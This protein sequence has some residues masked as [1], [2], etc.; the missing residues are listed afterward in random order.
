M[1]GFVLTKAG[2]V[3][4]HGDTMVKPAVGPSMMLFDEKNR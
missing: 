3:P 2:A 4:V 1:S